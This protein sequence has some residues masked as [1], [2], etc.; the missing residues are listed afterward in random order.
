MQTDTKENGTSMGL[1]NGNS[2]YSRVDKSQEVQGE[3]SEETGSSNSLRV[4]SFGY[5]AEINEVS[6][7]LVL[8]LDKSGVLG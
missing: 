8:L 2:R 6:S 4:A 7:G 1:R 5:I 3:I